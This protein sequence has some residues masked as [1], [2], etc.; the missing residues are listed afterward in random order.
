MSADSDKMILSLPASTEPKT[1]R[2]PAWG[3][4][5]R[6]WLGRVLNWVRAP[7]AIR[8]TDIHDEACGLHIRVRVYARFTEVSVNGREYRFC[9]LT[10]RLRGAGMLLVN[11]RADWRSAGTSE[12]TPSQADRSRQLRLHTKSSDV[13]P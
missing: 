12:S 4:F 3:E 10:G 1:S 2:W 11:P 8:A 13:Q 7:G 9:R 5:C 6:V